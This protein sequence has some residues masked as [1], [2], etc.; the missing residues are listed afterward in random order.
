[1]IGTRTKNAIRNILF[2]ILLRIYQI[3]IPFLIRTI[4]IYKLGIEYLG[5]N[6]LFAS[7]LGVLSLAELGFGT[8]MA[9]SLYRPIAEQ[10]KSMIC[11]L[12]NFYKIAYRIIGSIILTFGLIMMLFFPKLIKSDV[13]SD[14]NIYIVYLIQLLGSVSTYYLFAY[15]STLFIAHQRNDL[16][17]KV[18]II[19]STLQY[20]VQLFVLLYVNNFYIYSMAV[21]VSAIISN[22]IIAILADKYYPHYKAYGKI[23]EDMFKIIV[24]KVKA[25]FWV[26]LG[27]VVLN[28]VDSIVISAF[29]GLAILGKYNNYYYIVNSVVSIVG[30]LTTSIVAIIG[31]SLTIETKEKNYDVCIKLS[32]LNQWIVGW[33]TVCLICLYQDFIVIWVGKENVLSFPNALLF[34]VYFYILQSHQVAGAYKDAAGIWNHEQWRPLIV[35]VVNLV[36]NMLLVYFI[37][38]SGVILSTIISL[39][40]INTPW[41]ISNVCKL[42][43]AKKTSEYFFMWIKN[44]IVTVFTGIFCYTVVN[45]LPKNQMI[46]FIIKGMICC[47]LPNVCFLGIYYFDKR[48]KNSLRIIKN[49]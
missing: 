3:I 8:A 16:V 49:S 47:I 12:M 36:L 1:M 6:S 44:M 41:L 37:G 5:L 7:I 17:S 21:P 30:M 11:A 33:F 28:S 13:P 45:V 35:A 14:I 40:F 43:F 39:F 32:F 26:R 38:L 24:L 27:T 18:G 25:L 42:V 15:K 20:I 48:F 4:F 9:Y 23:K 2:A 10:N 29:L 34:S 22:L 31:N 19:V 46:Y